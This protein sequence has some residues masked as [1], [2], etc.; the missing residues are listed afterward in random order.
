MTVYVVYKHTNTINNKAYI[1]Q[2]SKPSLKLDDPVRLMNVRWLGHCAEA[3]RGSTCVFHKA[4]HNIIRNK[5]W[6]LT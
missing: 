6:K 4:I 5:T 1:G 2:V 3:K